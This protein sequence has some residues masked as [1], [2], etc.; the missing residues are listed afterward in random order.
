MI[1]F[2]LLLIFLLVGSSLPVSA[3]AGVV[4]DDLAEILVAPLSEPSYQDLLT[5]LDTASVENSVRL[6]WLHEVIDRVD[7]GSQ[8]EYQARCRQL[9]ASYLIDEG[10][11]GEATQWLLEGLRIAEANGHLLVE[12]LCYNGLGIIDYVR[13]R[14]EEASRYWSLAIQKIEQAGMIDRYPSLLS[15]LGSTYY[16]LNQLDS[17]LFFHHRALQLAEKLHNPVDMAMALNNLGNVYHKMADYEEAGTLFARA[18]T[19]QTEIGDTVEIVRVLNNLG[20]NF[21]DQEK[22]EQALDIYRHALE[23]ALK[24]GDFGVV[25]FTY[26]NLANAYASQG[27]YPEAYQ[28]LL[29][30][31]IAHDSAFAEEQELIIS[32]LR[33]Q[34]ETE[35]KEQEIVLLNQQKALDSARITRQRIL[36]IGSLLLITLMGML[37]WSVVR[38]RTRLRQLLLNIL[39]AA[40][41]DELNRTGITRARRH[42][43]VS[44]LFADFVG[45]TTISQSISPEKLVGLL[46]QYFSAFDDI[47]ERHVIEKIKTIG[48]AYMCASGLTAGKDDPV[49]SLV[50]AGQEMI[51]YARTRAAESGEP[52]FQL[53]VGIHTGPVVA[54]VV[55][56]K[57]FAY[58]IW[59]DTVNTAARMEQHGSPDEISI[60]EETYRHLKDRFDCIP[61]GEMKVKGKGMMPVY[62][63]RV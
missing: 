56:K 15:N 16:S 36:L 29:G 63:I 62:A 14:L 1:S 27:N 28:N 61:K 2:R 10:E 19:L 45:F 17:A 30:Y 25:A 46:N 43:Q 51:R 55:G 38:A 11:Y 41:V 7:R 18:L 34:Y 58:D 12:G 5:F 53:R 26:E 40:I 35:K 44:V 42:E 13:L 47:A 48:D 21:E 22:S 59:G 50:Q 23:V 52:H 33:T 32:R 6:L 54:G 9:L 60:S 31:V 24:G 57:K 8:T 20:V 3:Q 4:P 37:I 49:V 39:P